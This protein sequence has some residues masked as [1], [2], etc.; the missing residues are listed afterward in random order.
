MGLSDRQMADLNRLTLTLQSRFASDFQ[1]ISRLP[2]ADQLTRRAA[3]DHQFQ[4]DFIT[5]ARDVLDARQLNR[6]QQLMLQSGGFSS[7]A[8]PAVARQLGLTA[9]QI[10]NLQAAIDWSNGQLRDIN[11]LAATDRTR[12]TRLY[13]D[14]QKT[15]QDRFNRFLTADQQRTWAT[16]TGDPFAFQPAFPTGLPGLTTGSVGADGIAPPTT[17]PATGGTTTPPKQ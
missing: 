6:Y 12:A 13:A 14:Y 5:A 16:L 4:Q 3:L 8:D 11:A 15:F 10:G 9:T 2:A 17:T 7:L 1:G